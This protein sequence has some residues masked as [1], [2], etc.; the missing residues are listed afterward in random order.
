MKRVL[1]FGHLVALG[2]NSVIG[3]G[4][5]IVPGQL[6]RD[7]GLWSVL[8]FLA[9]GLL[10]HPV[11]LAFADLG[12][13]T[14]RSGGPYTYATL[15]FGDRWGFS[16]GWATWITAVVSCSAI[17]S[18]VSIYLGY[19]A[20]SLAPWGKTLSILSIFGFGVLNYLGVRY[21]GRATVIMTVLKT[22]PLVV[23][24]VFG[25]LVMSVLWRF[26]PALVAPAHHMLHPSTNAIKSAFLMALFTCQG[27]EVVPL[28]A[29]ETK[30]PRHFVPKAILISLWFPIIVYMGV[31]FCV[32]GNGFTSDTA[33]T[34][35]SRFWMG[36]LGADI[37]NATVLCS[38]IGF[39]A[40]T[41][42]GAPRLL[43]ALSEDGHIPKWFEAVHP[44]FQTPY[45][46]VVATTVLAM[47]LS[48][49]GNLDELI[50]ITALSV[51]VQYVASCA[52]LFALVRR[53]KTKGMITAVLGMLM[54]TFFL[55]QVE[56]KSWLIFILISCLGFGLRYFFLKPKSH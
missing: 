34:D 9:C 1:G 8:L 41:V 20:P 3:V 13:L 52:A 19:F 42:L 22:V 26:L 10:L 35:L 32:V 15:A 30:Q 46:S 38:V 40:G 2:V 21:G 39:L 54:S 53:G 4:I 48:I 28:I 6:S 16:V 7:L 24:F 5:F 44:K 37:I 55:F 11:A 27:F 25:L 12:K 45:L 31:Q 29:G 36:E 18:V 43:V 56:W 51:A 33:L 23:I 47:I 17:G 50:S 49:F 14:D